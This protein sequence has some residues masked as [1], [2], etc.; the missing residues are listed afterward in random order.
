[1]QRG[2]QKAKLSLDLLGTPFGRPIDRPEHIL[3]DYDVVFAAGR[4]AIEAVVSG[5]WVFPL[6]PYGCAPPLSPETV[7]SWRF[8]NFVVPEGVGSMDARGIFA[9]LRKWQPRRV[10]ATTELMRRESRFE[11]AVDRLEDIYATLLNENLNHS[12]PKVEGIALSNYLTSLAQK[13]KQADA[14]TTTLRQ[15]RDK[16]RA[17]WKAAKMQISLMEEHYAKL[18]RRLP[19]WL[20]RVLMR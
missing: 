16:A 4:S 8:H 13:V 7:A 15:Q 14:L 17:D 5:C 2:C 20:M 19:R 1:M 3:P 6:S 11:L 9:E 18:R 12:Q 10:Q